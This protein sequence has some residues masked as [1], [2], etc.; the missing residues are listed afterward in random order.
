MPPSLKARALR[1]L[2]RREYSRSELRT[3]LLHHAGKTAVPGP[4][5]TEVEPEAQAQQV[6][7]LLDELQSS[8]LLSDTRFIES[9]IHARAGRFGHTRIQHEL[10][11]H[12]VALGEEAAAE[13]RRTEFERARAL[14][15]RKFGAVAQD[16]SG[17]ARQARFLSGRGFS[18][19]VV[20]RLVRKGAE[21]D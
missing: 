10:A 18:A 19:E 2:A 20:R 16:P 15:L 12:G 21:G 7:Q 11:R 13:L 4:E 5:H 9:R 17:Q 14:W 3:K 1:A 6:E 8:G